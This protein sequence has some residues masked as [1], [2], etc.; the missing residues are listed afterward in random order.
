[1]NN[2][3]W[4]QVVEYELTGKYENSG[5]SA[6]TFYK[7]I[8]NKDKYELSIWLKRKDIDDIFSISGQ[9][10]DTQLITSSRDNVRS[11]VGRVIEMMCQKEMFDYYIERF[12]FTYKCCDLGGDIL[13]REELA[14]K[15]SGSEVA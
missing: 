2:K 3:Y 11:D 14:K 6:L 7:Y 9:K 13:E 1:M 12:E 15:N 8:S 4:G 10:I 5:Y